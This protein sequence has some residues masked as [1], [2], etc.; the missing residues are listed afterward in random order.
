MTADKRSVQT[1]ALAVLG[2]RVDETVGRDAIHLAVEPLVAAE[3]LYRGY[4]VGIGPDGRAYGEHSEHPLGQGVKMLGIVD[5]FLDCLGEPE[6]EEYNPVQPGERFLMVVFPRKITSL[7]HVWSHPDV[8]EPE[9]LKALE[10]QRLTKYDHMSPHEKWLR[11]YAENL[12]VDYDELIAEAAN[13]VKD[14]SGNLRGGNNLDG[15]YTSKEFWHHYL[16]MTGDDF[17]P[18]DL[19]NFFSCAC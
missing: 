17:P 19:G 11:Q 3:K 10:Q 8:P 16:A 1:D 12:Q 15:V 6:D 7:R 14:G 13:Q 4:K 5:P 9:Q 18:D 2:T